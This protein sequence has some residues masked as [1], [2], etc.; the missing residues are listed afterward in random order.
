MSGSLRL[1]GVPVLE[2]TLDAGGEGFGKLIEALQ[3]DG[4]LN[5]IH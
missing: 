1:V 4:R 3:S 2:P 5:V